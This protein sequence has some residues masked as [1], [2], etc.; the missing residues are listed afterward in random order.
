VL[1]PLFVFALLFAGIAVVM[2]AGT[3]LLQGSFYSEPVSQLYWRAPVAAA[4]VTLFIAG[5][6]YLA[7]RSPG[8]H[9]T[10]FDFT[11]T[12]D[13]FSAKQFWSVKHG[14]R[15][16]FV[17]KPT[18][19]RRYE[20]RDKATN[21]R[22][23]RSDADGLVETVIITDKD[24]RE[25]AFEA[26]LTPDH[27]FKAGPGEPARYIEVGGRHRVMMDTDIGR[28]STV[29]WGR[30]YGNVLLNILHVIVWFAALWLLLRFQWGHAL[31]LALVLWLIVTLAI[32][33]MLFKR[34]EDAARSSGSAAIAMSTR[35]CA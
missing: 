9:S 28:I 34:A 27:K 12:E 18:S 14:Q 24:G 17:A 5:W 8:T 16:L 3:L 33:P 13:E 1:P 6:C 35:V 2:F 23:S 25:I 22:W 21:K 20:Y 4:F 10:L 29:R 11:A 30:I 15:S 26:E 7:Y 19:G 31:G 32:M